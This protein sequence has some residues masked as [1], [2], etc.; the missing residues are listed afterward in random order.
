MPLNMM[1]NYN[2]KEPL[3]IV[4]THFMI[5]IA[6]PPETDNVLKHTE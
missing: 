3:S 6:H 1:Q 4:L 2:M 5:S